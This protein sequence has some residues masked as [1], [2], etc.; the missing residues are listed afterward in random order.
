MTEAPSLLCDALI[1]LAHL[2][3]KALVVG[4]FGDKRGHRL[5]KEVGDFRVC[6][7]LILNRVVQQCGDDDVRTPFRGLCNQSGDFDQM[8]EVRLRFLALPLLLRMFCAQRSRPL[9]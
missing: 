6:H 7:V 1:I 2:F 3:E 8:V 5:P 9:S 4:H